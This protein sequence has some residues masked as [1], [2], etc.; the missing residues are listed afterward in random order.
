MSNRPEAQDRNLGA[1][2]SFTPDDELKAFIEMLP[3]SN[4]TLPGFLFRAGFDR[5]YEEKFNDIANF[6]GWHARN[7]GL[8]EQHRE[9]YKRALEARDQLWDRVDPVAILGKIQDEWGVMGKIQV[10]IRQQRKQRGVLTCSYVIAKQ[11]TV[12]GGKWIPTRTFGP[13]GDMSK[14]GHTSSGVLTGKWFAGSTEVQAKVGV[15]FGNDELYDDGTPTYTMGNTLNSEKLNEFFADYY[16]HNSGGFSD[17]LPRKLPETI[18]R[19]PDNLVVLVIIPF[20]PLPP[21]T[22]LQDKGKGRVRYYRD[23]A[24]CFF[25]RTVSQQDILNHL[26]QLLEAQK[27][28]GQLPSQREALEMA[29]IAELRKR[30]L[31]IQIDL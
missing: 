13:T 9:T 3:T 22:F 31:L 18:W 1:A 24:Y 6:R 25:D 8:L 5:E 23:Q 2:S 27:R 17:I 26:L 19:R 16:Q 15:Y 29:K 28:I 30:E 7:A 12:G 21:G 4:I 10:Q 20:K 11:Q 14:G